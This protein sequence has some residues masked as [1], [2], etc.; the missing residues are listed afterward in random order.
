MT[1]RVRSGVRRWWPLA[2]VGAV[3]SAALS[4]AGSGSAPA[5]AEA[6]ALGFGPRDLRRTLV[7]HAA[8]TLVVALALGLPL[9]IAAGRWDS[10]LDCLPR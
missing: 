9:G 3:A 7:G 10:Q 5:A 2:L 4:L 6:T 1:S 8:S